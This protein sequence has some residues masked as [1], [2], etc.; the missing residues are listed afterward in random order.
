M[1]RGFRSVPLEGLYLML[2]REIKM[3]IVNRSIPALMDFQP[4][5]SVGGLSCALFSTDSVVGGTT[6]VGPGCHRPRLGRCGVPGRSCPWPGWRSRGVSAD[7]PGFQHPLSVDSARRAENLSSLFLLLWRSS[8]AYLE[9]RALTHQMPQ[10]RCS[11]GTLRGRGPS[12]EGLGSCLQTPV[13]S[14]GLSTA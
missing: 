8:G 6:F 10:P 14:K 1:R 13:S 9:G 2:I 12:A 4:L 11:P 5:L 3:K 7:R